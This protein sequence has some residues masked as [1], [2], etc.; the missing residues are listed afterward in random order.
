[1]RQMKFCHY[2]NDEIYN[3]CMTI[4]QFGNFFH[5]F[6]SSLRVFSITA[7]QLNIFLQIFSL[8]MREI[9][10]ITKALNGLIMIK[11]TRKTTVVLFRFFSYSL[12]NEIGV[13]VAKLAGEDK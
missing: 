3:Y 1:M 12:L 5:V 11:Y 2:L 8:E 10:T 4:L 13:S 6:Q 9:E 7:Q